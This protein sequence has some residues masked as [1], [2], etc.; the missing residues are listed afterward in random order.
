MIRKEAAGVFRRCPIARIGGVGRVGVRVGDGEDEAEGVL[1]VEVEAV[2]PLL[3]DEAE[4][5]V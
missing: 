3:A 4:G 1:A 5:L 2:Q